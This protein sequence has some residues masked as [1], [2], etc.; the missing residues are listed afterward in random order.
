MVELVVHVYQLN[1]DGRAYAHRTVP[2]FTF[3]LKREA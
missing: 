1:E 3:Q 2:F